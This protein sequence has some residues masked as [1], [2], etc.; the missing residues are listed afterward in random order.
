MISMSFQS[1][2]TDATIGTE[3]SHSS[4]AHAWV[5][6]RFLVELV[7]LPLSLFCC[8]VFFFVSFFFSFIELSVRRF[9]A[10]DYPCG[11]FKMF[12]VY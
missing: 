7:L 12:C 4:R 10:S 5:C 1:V 9:T 8:V 3:T 6:P 2:T 11:I